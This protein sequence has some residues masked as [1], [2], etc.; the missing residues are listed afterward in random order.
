MQFYEILAQVLELLQRQG[1]V[2]YR[3]LKRQFYLDDAYIEDLTADL[4]EART[5]LEEL[6]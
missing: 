6:A 4:Q 1:R 3:A 5:L 2:L